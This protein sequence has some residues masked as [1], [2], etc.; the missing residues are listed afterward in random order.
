MLHFS[1]SVSRLISIF[2][3]NCS[4]SSSCLITLAL[5][6]TN[7]F[8]LIKKSYRKKNLDITLHGNLKDFNSIGF[9]MGLKAIKKTYKLR[10]WQMTQPTYIFNAIISQ[11]ILF[12]I[13]A[14]TFK[15]RFNEIFHG[16]KHNSNSQAHILINGTTN[17]HLQCY[18]FPRYLFQDPCIVRFL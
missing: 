8:K 7:I 2:T 5:W 10:F 6:I 18:F 11:V 17:W 1:S 9:C 15:L 14:L 4:A 3:S 12:K 13:H 16:P